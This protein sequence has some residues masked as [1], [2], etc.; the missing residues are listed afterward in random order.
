MKI[1]KKATAILVPIVI[2]VL[3]ANNVNSFCLLPS[4][5]GMF[6][7]E[8]TNVKCGSYHV[9]WNF[10]VFNK[11]DEVVSFFYVGFVFFLLQ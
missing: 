10:R 3:A 7:V 9:V 5:S 1:S 11:I 6:G 2:F 8:R 4:S